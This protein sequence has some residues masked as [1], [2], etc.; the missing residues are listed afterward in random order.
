MNK[1]TTISIIGMHCASCVTRVESAIGSIRGVV[2][3]NI[4]L[5]SEKAFLEYDS[6]KVYL[7]KIKS[8]INDLGYEVATR[9]M[10]LSI[11]GMHCASCVTRVEKA[12]KRLSG[13]I[14]ADVNLVPEK[15]VVEEKEEYGCSVFHSSVD[16]IFNFD[17]VLHQLQG[18]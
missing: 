3:I 14:S 7:I 13:V 9:K 4:N 18:R 8:V 15:A 1:K 2:S 16:T 5:A 10:V 12:L 11:K 17:N 6:Q